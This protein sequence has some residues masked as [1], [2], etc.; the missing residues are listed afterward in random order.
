M[1]A[2]ADE[3]VIDSSPTGTTVRMRFDQV[4]NPSS[5]MA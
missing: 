5:A 2:L 3:V 4:S 1:E